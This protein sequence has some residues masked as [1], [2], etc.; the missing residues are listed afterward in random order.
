MILDGNYHRI[1][2]NWP[3]IEFCSVCFGRLR[4]KHVATHFV[5]FKP[6][7][8]DPRPRKR[9]YCDTCMIE[10]LILELNKERES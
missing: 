2:A 7:S 10:A 1:P 5:I 6:D 9:F 4:E 3:T 8:L